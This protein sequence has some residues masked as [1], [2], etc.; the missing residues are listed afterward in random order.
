MSFIGV[1]NLL[2]QI[3][4][5]RRP[6]WTEIPLLTDGLGQSF[7]GPPHLA[8]SGVGTQDTAAMRV[9]VGL[10][11][12]AARFGSYVVVDNL[13]PVS[14]YEVEI[15]ALTYT[16]S[17]EALTT[18]DLTFAALGGLI[19]R[20][21]GSWGT[22]GVTAGM[23]VYAATT[24]NTGTYTVVS[25]NSATEIAVEEA[26]VNETATPS[27]VLIPVGGFVSAA[28]VY[29]ALADAINTGVA[30]TTGDLT[31]AATGNTITRASGNWTADGVGVGTQIEVGTP[32]NVGSWTVLTVDSATQVTVI[33]EQAVTNETATPTYVLASE[34]VQ[35]IAGSDLVIKTYLGVEQDETSGAVIAAVA[36][37]STTHTT[38]VT[39]SDSDI[40]FT[41]DATTADIVLYA[42][43]RGS[44]APDGWNA[45]NDC[46]FTLTKNFDERFDFAG[47][48][49]ID[50]SV[51]NAD[52]IVRVFAGPAVREGS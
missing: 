9:I 27:A 51:E 31:L 12:D 13:D 41:Q 8:S 52:G 2:A 33:P 4:V 47:T 20:A 6:D 10:R 17:P 16:V 45:P 39:A 19:T 29:A 23:Q 48:G 35:A 50:V 18:G 1:A 28:A 5:G 25:V 14:D 7:K 34:Q 24:L 11:R 38:A 26:V 49:R 43:P 42:R 44:N 32:L 37:S 30:L 22:D 40:S 36:N 46:A 3:I 15:N 21:S